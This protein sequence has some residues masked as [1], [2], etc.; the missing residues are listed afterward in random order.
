MLM[1]M[2]AVVNDDDKWLATLRGIQRTFRHQTVTAADIRNYMSKHT[3]TDLSKIFVQYQET[4]MVPTLE[5]RSD[6]T[7]LSYR[8]TDVV[9]GFA[10]PVR[11]AGG[12][13]TT[14]TWLHPTARWQAM[15]TPL[16]AS[17]TLRVDPEF[18]VMVK[19]V[20]K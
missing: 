7:K 4:T 12:A 9:P 2:R 3:G 17:D 16:G 8:W 20:E 11:V 6:G 19:R 10:M 15:R 1:T 18:Y 14:W 5:Y 13:D